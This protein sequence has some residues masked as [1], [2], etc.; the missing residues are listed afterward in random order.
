MD[1]H[2]LPDDSDV[3]SGSGAPCPVLN[4]RV[5]NHS[6]EIDGDEIDSE[7]FWVIGESIGPFFDSVE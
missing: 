5:H 1:S 2:G 4:R 3:T 6:V 7:W